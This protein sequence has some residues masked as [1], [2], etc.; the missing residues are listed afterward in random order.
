MINIICSSRYKIERKKIRSFTNQ[1]L[2]DKGVIYNFDLNIIFVGKNKMRQISQKYKQENVALPVLS[3]AYNQKQEDKIFLGEIF[4]CYPQA[5]LL[6]AQRNKKVDDIIVS[7]IK[8][9]LDSIV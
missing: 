7:L 6:A 5:V 3:F 4:I 8:H 1:L 2:K 9:G